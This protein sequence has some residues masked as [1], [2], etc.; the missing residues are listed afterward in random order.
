MAGIWFVLGLQL[1][2]KSINLIS[3]VEAVGFSGE[4][5]CR[6]LAR[7]VVSFPAA[8]ETGAHYAAGYMGFTANAEPSIFRPGG[9]IPSCC[10]NQNS[11]TVNVT[12]G[13]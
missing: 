12:S 5:S 3:V 2:H 13:W 7:A 1:K 6:I 9:N 4:E 8:A 11:F 10:V